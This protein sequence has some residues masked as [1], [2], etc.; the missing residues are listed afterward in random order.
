LVGDP[1]VPILEVTSLN[2]SGEL[3][4]ELLGRP[5]VRLVAVDRVAKRIV[6]DREQ[7]LELNVESRRYDVAVPCSGVVLI[8]ATGHTRPGELANRCAISRSIG[9]PVVAV[10][11]V[12]S[13]SLLRGD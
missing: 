11:L 4:T 3:V 12:D 9:P 13:V 2:G 10:V 5:T 7:K 6:R 1:K 8:G